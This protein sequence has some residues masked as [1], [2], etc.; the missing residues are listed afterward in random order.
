MGVK[1]AQLRAG[2]SGNSSPCSLLAGVRGGQQ[3]AGGDRTGCLLGKGPELA[4]DLSGLVPPQY[5]RIIR[6][7]PWAQPFRLLWQ[8][9]SPPM[10]CAQP[11]R[12]SLGN[13]VYRQPFPC[14]DARTQT[15][16]G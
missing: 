5:C 9:P 16:R 12:A 15:K 1:A 7:Q 8:E 13:P 14:V 11:S 4:W 2:E 10:R 6:V 3:W